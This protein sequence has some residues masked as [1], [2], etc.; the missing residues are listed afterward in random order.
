M[1]RRLM[2]MLISVKEYFLD[3]YRFEM[4]Q[5]NEFYRQ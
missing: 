2:D 3:V 4:D 5:I 1:F